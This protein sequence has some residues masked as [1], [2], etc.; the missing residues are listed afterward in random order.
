MSPFLV[1]R[2]QQVRNHKEDGHADTRRR[3][4]RA[5]EPKQ[6]TDEERADNPYHFLPGCEQEKEERSGGH[7]KDQ[8]QAVIRDRRRG[9]RERHRTGQQNHRIISPSGGFQILLPGQP[10]KGGNGKQ[11]NGYSIQDHTQMAEYHDIVIREGT[12]QG[13]HD[14]M[15]IGPDSLDTLITQITQQIITLITRNAIPQ[16]AE[17]EIPYKYDGHPRKSAV[18]HRPTE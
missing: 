9:E 14:G 18:L 5:G 8:L 2:F 6:E 10:F 4:I 1:L 12:A 11:D 15:E 17:D 13:A 3:I 16:C 7:G